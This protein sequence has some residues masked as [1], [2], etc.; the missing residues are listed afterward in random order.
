[1]NSPFRIADVAGI[2]IRVHVTFFLILLLAAY[3]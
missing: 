2:P 3:Q 1:M